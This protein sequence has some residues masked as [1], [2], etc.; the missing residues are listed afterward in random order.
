[1]KKMMVVLTA[2]GAFLSNPAFADG[3]FKSVGKVLAS[4]APKI[5]S[6]LLQQLGI[7]V[8]GINVDVLNNTPFVGVLYVYGE[9]TATIEPG[10]VA[11][12]KIRFEPLNPPVPII[13]C[14]EGYFAFAN[15]CD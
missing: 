13:R 7:S 3:F 14:C 11:H 8:R 12:G 10:D 5:E 15:A 9:K 4:A 1:M 2:L 6:P